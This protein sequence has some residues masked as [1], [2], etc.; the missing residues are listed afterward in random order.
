MITTAQ[1]NRQTAQ[2]GLDS[3]YQNLIA[4]SSRLPEKIKDVDDDEAE[5]SDGEHEGPDDSDDDE[6]AY[7]ERNELEWVE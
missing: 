5:E 3:A 1:H 2:D 6:D 7:V 4:V